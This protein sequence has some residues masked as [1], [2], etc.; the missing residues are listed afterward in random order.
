MRWGSR[1]VSKIAP[2]RTAAVQAMS[3]RLHCLHRCRANHTLLLNDGFQAGQELDHAET[4]SGHLPM[5]V[6]VGTAAD[7]LPRPASVAR[8]S[9]RTLDGVSA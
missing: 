3:C 8:V 5:A 1:W 2:E 9:E 4:D 6:R 7:G